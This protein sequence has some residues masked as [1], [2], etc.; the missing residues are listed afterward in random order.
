MA[1]GIVSPTLVFIPELELIILYVTSFSAAIFVLYWWY[2]SYSRLGISITAIL[3]YIRKNWKAMIS[4][5]LSYGAFH[6]KTVRNTYAG[7]MHLLIFYG[8]LILFIST[9]LIALS[10]DILKPLFHFGILTGT[11]Y[12]NFEVWANTG[13]LMLMAGL[14]MALYRRLAK[15][16]KLESFFDDY[17][18]ISGLLILSIEGFFLG[19][20]KIA[21]F[22]NGFDIYRYIEW[23]LSY[24]FPAG[25]NVNTA[26]QVYRELWLVHILT[27][28]ALAIYLPF[29]KFSHIVLSWT[30]VTI[31]KF[32]PR[33]EL[34][35][36]FLL[37]E[38]LETGNIDFTVGAK[39]VANLSTPMKIDSLACTNCGRCER[40]CPAV[41][42]GSDL[43]PRLVVQNVKAVV[44][45]GKVE[46]V[47]GILSE[48]AAWACTTCQ[49]C[50]EECP[51]LIDPHS[52]VIEARRNL[53]MENKISKEMG[54]YFNNLTN[55]QNPY[56]N[57]PSDRDALLKFGPKYDSSKEVLYWAGCMGA[58]DP[59]GKKI[60]ETV[61]G[62]LTKAGVNFGILGSE[63]KC[64]G[65]TARRMGEEG[66]FQ[67]LVMQ[68]IDTFKKYNVK[69]IITACPHCY[70]T[71][72]NEYPKFGLQAEI[73]HHSEFLAKLVDDGKLK[74]KKTDETVTLHD[75]CYLGRVNGE[76]DNTRFIVNSFGNLKEMEK[77]RQNSMCC[78]AGGGNYWYK[79]KS[80]DSISHL[81]MQ[82]AL[83]TKATKLAVACPFCNAMMDDAS[84]SMDAQNKIEIKDVSELISENLEN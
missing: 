5:A 22:R 24:I 37:S 28:F 59:R 31:K 68:N 71:F 80:Q 64:N 7:V 67:E 36:P 1:A 19:A 25:M 50:V 81:R 43:D 69:K 27:A 62:L 38:A 39:E 35:T 14:C 4:Q 79:V 84:R 63:E 53:V 48:N 15:K 66:R 41:L 23:Y 30:N 60:A 82:Q 78:G 16:V 47:P 44:Y 52:F 45:N 70:N 9:S 29:S 76:Y 21:L 46:M 55:T 10:H 75:P 57:S 65:E 32:H 42:S 8:M 13:G 74:V 26:I 77:S 33:G 72:K 54:Q 20:L 34:S 3:D 17:I 83:D 56:G 73:V 12:L 2:R 40:A 49:A 58:F 51:V 18:L 61:M 11:F 6:K